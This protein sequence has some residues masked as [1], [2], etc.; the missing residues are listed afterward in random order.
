MASNIEISTS[1]HLQVKRM[2][3][4][5]KLFA[6]L[7]CLF[8]FFL[9]TLLGLGIIKLNV[10]TTSGA[11]AI[12]DVVTTTGFDS[13]GQPLPSSNRFSLNE[14]RIYCF[15]TVKSP[16]PVNVG[17]RWF[18]ENSLIYE[19]NATFNGSR[20]FFLQPLPG[21]VFQQGDYRVEIYLV[22]ETLRTVQFSV[23]SNE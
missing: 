13:Q 3:T 16:N 20:A 7:G 12:T 5:L 22:E 10:T 17:V 21:K 6:G 4:I 14:T 2:R 11:I 1:P 9:I 15:V 23:I 18:F 19:D 8:I